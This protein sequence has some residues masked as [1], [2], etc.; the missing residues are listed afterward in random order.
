[1]NFVIRSIRFVDDY[2]QSDN[3]IVQNTPRNQEIY[4]YTFFFL[5]FMGKKVKKIIFVF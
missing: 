2:A 4:I 5:I 3:N 1:M